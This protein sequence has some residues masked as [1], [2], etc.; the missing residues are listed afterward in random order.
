MSSVRLVDPLPFTGERVVPGAVERDLWNEHVSRYRFATLFAKQK[1]VLDLGCGTGYGAEILTS[2]A[3]RTVALDNSAEAIA[4][5]SAHFSNPE[6]L[7][8][9]AT[10]LP[11]QK[12]S[13][14]LITAFEVI[15]HLPH[16]PL[17]LEEAARV[18]APEG[19]FLVSTPNRIAYSE[20]RGDVGPNPFHVHEF[21]LEEFEKALTY[22][23]PFVRVL[24][25]NHQAAIVFSSEQAGPSKSFLP[26]AA[27]SPEGHFFL[28]VCARR[29][30]TIPSFAFVPEA[31]NLLGEREKHIRLLQA[32]VRDLER[33][34]TSLMKSHRELQDE[35]D[36]H[37]SWALGLEK[38]L[39]R[40]REQLCR[41]KTDLGAAAAS[42]ATAEAVSRAAQVASKSA[43]TDAQTKLDATQASLEAVETDRRG[44][45]IRLQA[46]Q[47]HNDNLV[48]V[49]EQ[50]WN[51][52]WIRFGRALHVGPGSNRRLRFSYIS[53]SARGYLLRA[54]ES[55]KRGAQ[56]LAAPFLL[57]ASAAA[58]LAVDLA[59]YLFGKRHLPADFS[60]RHDK[61]SI[62][63]PNW[64]GRDLLARSL[65]PLLSAIDLGYGNEIIIV[66]NASS[67]GSPDFIRGQ[68][69]EVRLLELSENRGFAGACNAAVSAAENEVV[70]L[71]NNDMRVRS[72]FLAPL[73]QH[74]SDPQVFAVSSQIFFADPQRRR[75]ETGLTET[76][77]SD[78]FLG[79]GHRVDPEIEVAYPCA[80]PGGGSSAF[81]RSKFLE[82]GGFDSLFHP[83]YYE[84]TDLGRLAWKR[85]WKVLY[86]PSSIVFHE[87]R[88]T[89]GKHFSPAH[90]ESILRKNA[91]VYCWKNIH[92]WRLLASHFG[93]CLLSTV[94]VTPNDPARRCSP[95]DALRAFRQLVQA[96]CSRWRALATKAVSDREAFNRPLGGYFHDRFVAPSVPV[97]SRLNVLFVSP[98]PIEPPI[99]GGA[100][101]M[102]ETLVP[103]SA[104]A[105]IH[106]L[107][108]VDNEEQLPAQE[109]LASLCKTAQFTVRPHF[110]IEGVWAF[111]PCAIQEFGVRDF[112]WRIHRTIYFQKVDVLQIEYTILGQYAGAFLHIPCF[113]F[114]HDI[115]VQSLRRRL[116]TS[117][118]DF[119]LF[120]EYLRM[121]IYEPGL[122]KRFS[123]V[124]VCSGENARFL[125]RLFPFWC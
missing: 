43:L 21:D 70:V 35:L 67:D 59:F 34:A 2:D 116:T 46:A 17:L 33:D 40:A 106:L 113:L 115:S 15:E 8:A 77:W 22:H 39:V 30:V 95:S 42:L 69:P 6:F 125:L 48:A 65:P 14:G 32:R 54:C 86:E 93:A 11:F 55:T 103:L 75:E 3:L 58:L 12:A 73:L 31:G 74:F 51:S 80:Y 38:E 117:R 84:D 104:I 121:R 25:Q 62:I 101:F 105:D 60:P 63:I 36:H 26:P 1:Q 20:T 87:H 13:F 78:G 7:T 89:I 61:A 92:D 49:E 108:F 56:Y 52:A 16:W 23:F 41:Y 97:P 107:S 114:E 47:R 57:L 19:V 28:A 50:I 102:K 68:F 83:F 66:D 123:R 24:S 85:G 88:G 100:V 45:E 18:L 110:P 111:T 81:D 124:Q 5:A 72:G 112:A 37:N 76:W 109:S 120:L 64:N 10:E 96:S 4:F 82:L 53:T 79:V 71:L 98:Y 29:P 118:F 90:I 122:L 99:H 119:D 91:I 27:A 9:S 94:S 44:F